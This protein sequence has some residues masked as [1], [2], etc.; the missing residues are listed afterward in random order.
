MLHSTASHV[1]SSS[2]WGQSSVPS[3]S[4]EL[5]RGQEGLALAGAPRGVAVAAG[6]DSPRCS[7]RW[8]RRAG[9]WC[10]SRPA[11][12]RS[13][14]RP[15]RPRSRARRC[16]AA[17]RAR[18]PRSCTCAEAEA[19]TCLYSRHSLRFASFCFAGREGSLTG[20]RPG[21]RPGRSGAG[22]SPRRSSRRSHCRRRSG[23][24]RARTAG[25][26]T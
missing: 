12:D 16:S 2:P 1:F 19:G 20:S 25:T 14:A 23:T 10:R 17:A 26:C 11:E 21:R 8:S 24:P 7:S 18:S 4:H 5:C 22:S 15:R 6:E 13:P 3:H 9:P